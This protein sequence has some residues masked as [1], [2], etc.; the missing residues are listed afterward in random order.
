MTYS[1]YTSTEEETRGAINI[2]CL[3]RFVPNRF[4]LA[5]GF[6]P[7]NQTER[8]ALRILKKYHDPKIWQAQTKR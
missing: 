7:K 8:L 2:Q 5:P 6:Y 4:D 3:A 1:Q